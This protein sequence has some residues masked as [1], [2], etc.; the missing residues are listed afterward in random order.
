[1]AKKISVQ[2]YSVRDVPLDYETKI[3][4]IAEMGYPAVEPAGF[5][6]SSPEKAAKLFKEL[7]L[8]I[9]GAHFS[10]PVGD[11]KQEILETLEALGKPPL[12]D[13]QI[14]PNDVTSLDKIKALCD[15]LNQ[16]YEVAKA[17]GLSYAI[18]NHWWEFGT[19]DGRLVHDVMV[20][21][22]DPGVLFEIDT[23][24][25][26]VGGSDPVKV[27]KKLGTRVPFLHIKDGPGTKEGA[28]T[29]VGDGIMDVP[30]LLD[31][32]LPDVWQVVELD[33]CDTDVMTAIKKSYDYLANL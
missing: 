5:P 10:T 4:K 9:S 7:G 29:A 14:G 28:M 16:G 1:M 30:A 18:H 15:R 17:Y 6:G 12:I 11:K 31:A 21:L 33:E 27:I 26:K 19:V 25:V 24:W 8:T 20:D 2:L 32:A 22:L 13:T 3:R 23:Y